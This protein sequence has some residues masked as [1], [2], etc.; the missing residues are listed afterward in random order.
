M[1]ESLGA[2]T[3]SFPSDD[4]NAARTAANS[5]DVKS[6]GA[7]RTIPLESG[8]KMGV[9][10]TVTPLV[11]SRF[12]GIPHKGIMQLG[13]SSD[14]PQVV[15]SA[16]AGPSSDSIGSFGPVFPNATP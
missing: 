3:Q 13:P 15:C 2:L 5:E 10:G 14:P 16:F 1:S 12:F 11:S 8:S 9:A 4:Q 6:R 7:I